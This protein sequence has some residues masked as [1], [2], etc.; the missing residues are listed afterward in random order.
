MEKFGLLSWRDVFLHFLSVTSSPEEIFMNLMTKAAHAA[1]ACAALIIG[2]SALAQTIAVPG[3]SAAASQALLSL[4]GSRNIG[5]IPPRAVYSQAGYATGGAALRNVASGGLTLSGTF[6]LPVKQAFLYWAYLLKPGAIAPVSDLIGFC[7]WNAAACINNVKGAL[8]AT[9][10]DTCWGSDGLAVFRADVTPLVAAAGGLGSYR[11]NVNPTLGFSTS[12]Q[13]PWAGPIVF[14]AMEGASL[15]A[16]GGG[17][18]TVAVFDT[19]TSGGPSLTG[20]TFYSQLGYALPLPNSV[21]VTPVL[22]DNI[23]ADGQIGAS[24]TPLVANETVTINGV[25][26][27]GS[28]SVVEDSDWDGGSGWP[29]PQLWDDTGHDITRAAP[30]ATPALKVLHQSAGDCL[31]TIANVVAY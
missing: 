2:S 3:T 29:L 13:D 31:S 12:G 11:V 28:G 15:V 10:A 17:A 23:G 14:P 1:A 8:I 20:Q 7:A 6:A 19:T 22:W 26:I 4:I 16:I 5:V 9:G 21:A 30:P 24:R 27:S 25:Q 18:Q